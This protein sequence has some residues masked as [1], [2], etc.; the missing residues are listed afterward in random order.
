MNEYDLTLKLIYWVLIL[1]RPALIYVMYGVLGDQHSPASEQVI[2]YT[3]MSIATVDGILS[4][5]LYKKLDNP[6]KLGSGFFSKMNRG[7]GLPDEAIHW[8]EEDLKNY[9]KDHAIVN[10]SIIS[11]ALGFA[12]GIFGIMIPLVGGT[13]TEGLALILMSL[14][15]GLYQ[16]PKENLF[17]ARNK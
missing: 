8:T 14:G 10:I 12:V 6:E 16:K 4:Y 9:R 7:H 1:L 5:F 15:L 3:I 13:Q 2:V 11:W 17:N